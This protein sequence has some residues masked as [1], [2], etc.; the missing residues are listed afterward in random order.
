MNTPITIEVHEPTAGIVVLR[1]SG[2]LDAR[3]A[4]ELMTHCQRAR[5]AGKDVVLNLAAVPFIASSGIGSLLALFDE[6]QQ[7]GRNVRLTQLS[8][9]VDSVIRLLNLDAFFAMDASEEE[10]VRQ[11]RAA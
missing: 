11:L 8:P 1:V 3:A 2:R 9:A 6:F 5:D 10:S 4:S 7:A